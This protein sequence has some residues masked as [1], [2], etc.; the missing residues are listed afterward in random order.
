MTAA[1]R[2]HDP[3]RPI[4]VGMLPIK[5]PDREKS[6]GFVPPRSRTTSTSSPSTSTPRAKNS[7]TRSATLKLFDVG[8][9]LVI[10]EIFPLTATP[11]ELGQFIEQSRAI[12]DGWI[13]FYWGRTIEEMKDDPGPF[14]KSMLAWLGL[15]RS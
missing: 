10:E 15:S 12:A 5:P 9:P 11:K 7:T 6:R 1:I 2:K 3:R 8:K 4:T 13:G 14:D